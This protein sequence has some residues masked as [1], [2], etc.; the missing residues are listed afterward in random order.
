[1]PREW[2]GNDRHGVWRLCRVAD[3]AVNGLGALRQKVCGLPCL[4]FTSW[5]AFSL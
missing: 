4:L 3:F 2:I 1:M 5:R